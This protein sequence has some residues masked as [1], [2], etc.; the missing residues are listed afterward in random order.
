MWRGK[1]LHDRHLLTTSIRKNTKAP[2]CL[3]D[4]QFPAR[5]LITDLVIKVCC[6]QSPEAVT[7]VPGNEHA[8]LIKEEKKPSKLAFYRGN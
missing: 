7:D 5:L 1:F 6:S 2:A 4:N 3:L 8:N